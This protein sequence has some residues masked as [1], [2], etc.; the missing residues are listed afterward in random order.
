MRKFTFLMATLFVA[1]QMSA[2]THNYIDLGLS[3]KWAT[4]NI[5]A[6]TPEA[7][8]VFF[9]WGETTSKTEENKWVDYEHCN[10]MW[11]TLTKYC[12]MSNYGQDGYTDE[13]TVLESE[14]DAAT[15]N[16]GEDWRMPTRT[17]CQELV[18]NCT[19]TVSEQ[20]GVKGFVVTGENGNSIFLPAV[21]EFEEDGY[22]V[23]G[24][25]LWTASLG[26][27]Y[28]GTAFYLSFSCAVEIATNEEY[29]DI[30]VYQGSS[31]YNLQ[32]VRPV[33]CGDAGA[34]VA[35]DQ[36]E[37]E[38]AQVRKVVENGVIYIVHPNGEKYTL[39]GQRAK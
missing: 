6:T 9:A 2:Q 27:E 31:R 18:D 39:T 5:G 30:D 22:R 4:C 1:A 37:V 11:N 7:A 29:V 17:E 26:D 3:V 8:G 16:W 20:N 24:A 38:K 21:E 35:I 13:L 36:V 34:T 32:L 10:G 28:P 15:V 14:D 33:F 23:F 12:F 19:W 25:G